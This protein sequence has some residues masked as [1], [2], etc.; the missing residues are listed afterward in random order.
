MNVTEHVVTDSDTAQ[1]VGSGDLPVLATPRLAQW[2]E[3]AAF[4]AAAQEVDPGHTTVGT[5]LSVE[6]V[7]P[8]ALGDSVFIHCAKPVRDGRRII[9]AIRAE[10]ADG[11]EI[12]TGKVHRAVVDPERFMARFVTS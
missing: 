1:A 2:F 5:L 3:M 11:L 12:A 4:A 9:F 7:R 6:H 10:D 8:T